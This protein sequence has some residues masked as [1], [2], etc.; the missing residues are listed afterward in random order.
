MT[1]KE[2]I[3]AIHEQ[4]AAAS[5]E[6]IRSIAKVLESANVQD[7]VLPRPLTSREL[8]L[9]EQSKADFAE[10]R[11][12]TPEESRAYIEARLAERRSAHDKS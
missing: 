7:S 6:T 2:T 4:L 1:R 8:A 9:I 3:A 11:S 12:Y 10:G 5:D